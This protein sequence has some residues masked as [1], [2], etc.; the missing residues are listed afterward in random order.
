[1]TYSSNIQRLRSAERNA[2]ETI[3]NQNTSMAKVEG[4]KATKEAKEIA[5]GLQGFSESSDA[6]GKQEMDKQVA[7]GREEQRRAEAERAKNLTATQ[8]EILN[9]ENQL[10]DSN[11]KDQIEEAKLIDIKLQSLKAEALKLN[12]ING[13]YDAERVAQ[14]SP[15]RQI[16]FHK[17]RIR[18]N[19][20]K[21]P[22][23][24]AERLRN[25]GDELSFTGRDGKVIKFK[26]NEIHGVEAALPLK[27]AA[28]QIHSDKLFK[29]LGFDNYSGAYL[30]N[31]KV[32]DTIDKEEDSLFA[33]YSQEYRIDDSS[34][35]RDRADLNLDSIVESGDLPT[36]TDIQQYYL[37][38]GNTVDAKDNA[39]NYKGAIAQ[40]DNWVV[41]T[42]I[43]RND[44]EFALKI[45]NQQ[46][47]DSM[48][49]QLKIPIGTTFGEHWR[50]KPATLRKQIEK[51][52]TDNATHNE[53][54]EGARVD[55]IVQQA[56]ALAEQGKWT[57]DTE[58]FALNALGSSATQN[59]INKILNIRTV[60][61]QAIEE[62][63]RAA[64]A[65]FESQGNV[66]TPTQLKQFHPTAIAQLGYKK[67]AEEY[68]NSILD[69]K[70]FDV[71]GQIK[72]ALDHQI[73][74]MG[75][76]GNE[77]DTLYTTSMAN[78][79][80][81]FNQLYSHFYEIHKNKEIAI[82]K[83]LKAND[84]TEITVHGTPITVR[85]VLTD[86]K[87]G[88]QSQLLSDS[89]V[90]ATQGRQNE[91]NLLLGEVLK[92]KTQI[93]EMT[94]SGIALDGE[95]IGGKYGEKMLQSIIDNL[96]R[97]PT[98]PWLGYNQ[99]TKALDYYSRIA[100][101]HNMKSGY[102]NLE[103]VIDAQLRA[104]GHP[105]ILSG[106]IEPIVLNIGGTPT[107]VPPINVHMTQQLKR[108]YSGEITDNDNHQYLW[109]DVL[110]LN[111]FKDQSTYM[112]TKGLIDGA[113][114]SNPFNWT[115]DDNLLFF[116]GG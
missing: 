94:N 115:D 90:Y 104:V 28:I 3:V 79:T 82:Q 22:D 108:L 36:G 29:E 1:M 72:A 84:G 37:T 110:R 69:N 16:G 39:L 55:T 86:L 17:E 9:L 31:Q 107:E 5:L 64:K 78:A 81:T 43:N 38:V 87:S 92:A 15:W 57:L 10:T 102:G 61:E 105:G 76:K 30:R 80:S 71:R 111:K 73:T 45:F 67:K 97:N 46:M 41:T 77:K 19:L 99:S 101:G 18:T 95:V 27:E 93:R 2:Y 75:V 34:K 32:Y 14:L 6:W 8:K 26:A 113:N 24:L 103:S 74:G 52:I 49:K 88:D 13:Y 59:D 4:D 48:C 25:S 42:G 62:S 68:Q 70:E 106:N 21:F 35:I 89:F 112:Y 20:D 100:H 12:G 50:K 53:K 44:P 91:E 63:K 47:P 51:G 98:N 60:S 54:Y 83:A 114:D 33:K 116:I 66:I 11:T 7:E 65:L 96:E 109:E 58:K 56:R 85:G 40:F 23:L